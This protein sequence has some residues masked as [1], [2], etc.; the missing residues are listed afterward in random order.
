VLKKVAKPQ[1]HESGGQNIPGIKMGENTVTEG[2]LLRVRGFC[3]P[4]EKQPATSCGHSHSCT[5]YAHVT[6]T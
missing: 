3:S 2:K 1:S 6:I 4:D 5:E